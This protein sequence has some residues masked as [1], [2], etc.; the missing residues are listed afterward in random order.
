MAY[1]K[2]ADQLDRMWRWILLFGLSI[3]VAAFFGFAVPYRFWPHETALY[4][5]L[6]SVIAFLWGFLPGTY[7]AFMAAM[8]RDWLSRADDEFPGGRG[9]KWK[10]PFGQP[11]NWYYK[12]VILTDILGPREETL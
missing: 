9:Q 1:F 11:P 3:G 6:Y 5:I 4:V 12:D 8:F 10:R 2:T 7:I